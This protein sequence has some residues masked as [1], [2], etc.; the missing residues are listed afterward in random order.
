MCES[1]PLSAFSF[2]IRICEQ[3]PPPGGGGVNSLHNIDTPGK[4]NPNKQN[5]TKPPKKPTPSTQLRDQA[6]CEC[7]PSSFLSAAGGAGRAGGC[8]SGGDPGLCSPLPHAGHGRPPF[9]PCLQ[10]RACACGGRALRCLSGS[11]SL[12]IIVINRLMHLAG[13]P[14]PWGGGGGLRRRSLP[15]WRDFSCTYSVSGDANAPHRPGGAA[16]AVLGLAGGG[17][18]R[19]GRDRAWGPHGARC[20][21]RCEGPGRARLKDGEAH[22]GAKLH[23]WGSA[24]PQPLPPRSRAAPHPQPPRPR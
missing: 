2:Q 13:L 11:V 17:G 18:A 4:K 1:Q 9:A 10:G 20:V 22:V 7:R 5:P 16:A 3:Q 19:G 15:A 8:W 21:G 6:D 23:C 12:L 14:G 24:P